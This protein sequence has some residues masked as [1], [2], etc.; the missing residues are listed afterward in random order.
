MN[1]KDHMDYSE[2]FVGCQSENDF[3]AK[4]CIE[5][6]H[7]CYIESLNLSMSFIRY[8]VALRNNLLPYND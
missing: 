6:L 4:D 3:S 7:W 1:I 5:L 8:D 2:R